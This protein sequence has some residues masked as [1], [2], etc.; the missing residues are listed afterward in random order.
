MKF[1]KF[2]LFMLAFAASVS[3]LSS[4]GKDDMASKPT[5]DPIKPEEPSKDEAMTAAEQK[6]R[7]DAIAKEFMDMIPASDFKAIAELADYMNETFEDYDW[8]DVE[9]WA[10]DAFD[11]T[12][13]ALG[14][15]TETET[16]DDYWSEITYTN[17]YIYTDYKALI[18]ASNFT[19]HFTAK[20][21]KWVYSKASDLQFI[22]KDKAG[23]DCVAKLTTGGSVKKVFLG[24]FEEWQ[25]YDWSDYVSNDYY[26]RTEMT[27]GVPE[28]IEVSLT[29]GGKQVVKT[30][31]NIDLSGVNNEKFDISKGSLSLTAETD[32]NNGYKVKASQVAYKPNS[33]VSATSTFSKDDKILVSTAI[34]SDIT[35]IPSYNVDAFTTEDYDDDELEDDFANATAKNALVKVDILGKL[36]IQGTI[37]DVR[38][39]AE[40]LYDAD[41]KYYDDEKNYKSYINQANGLMDVNLFYDGNA[42]KQATVKLEPFEDYSDWYVEPV[43]CFYDGTSYSSFEAF[44]NDKDFKSVMNAFKKWA[45][46]YADLFDEE[47]DWDF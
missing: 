42:K 12:R 16:W 14:S 25:D 15:H 36:Q 20:D 26:D 22:F 28:K 33:T 4:C 44:F 39:F 40:Y 45:N 35:G 6:E 38:K 27:I 18:L 29:Q 13:T 1:L 32:F 17:N 31:V 2:S 30:T 47:I 5:T 19:G 11:A 21:E 41:D 10:D 24:T 3:V 7:L 34:A 46:A 8:D 37:K 23:K 9:D 43:L